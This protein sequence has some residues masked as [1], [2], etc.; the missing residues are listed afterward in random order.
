MNLAGRFRI[1]LVSKGNGTF[2]IWGRALGFEG[3]KLGV[4]SNHIRFVSGPEKLSQ[5]SQISDLTD[6]RDLTGR[7]AS[8]PEANSNCFRVYPPLVV[9]TV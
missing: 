2:A 1:L 7:L 5:N 8:D 6:P 9:K 3:S 4:E